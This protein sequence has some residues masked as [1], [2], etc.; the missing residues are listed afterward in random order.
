MNNKEDLVQKG[1]QAAKEAAKEAG[2][3]DKVDQLANELQQTDANAANATKD[4]NA[5]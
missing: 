3:S 4:G 5:I 1:L 2:M